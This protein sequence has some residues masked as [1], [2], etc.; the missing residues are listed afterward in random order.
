MSEYEAANY[1]EHWALADAVILRTSKQ[2][3]QLVRYLLNHQRAVTVDV[4]RACAI[5]NIS[6]VVRKANAELYRVGLFIG[7]ET[8]LA[9]IPIPNRF[10][11]ASQMYLWFIVVLPNAAHLQEQALTPMKKAAPN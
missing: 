6:D 9:L 5:G 10:D 2:Q 11:E 3:R 4:N 8:P 7:C 1:A